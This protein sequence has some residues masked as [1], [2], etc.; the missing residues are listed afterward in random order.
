[1]ESNPKST[2]SSRLMVPVRM[3]SCSI[4][5]G[6]KGFG[7]FGSTLKVLV[8]GELRLE[9][10][11]IDFRAIWRWVL[12]LRGEGDG[13]DNGREATGTNEV[14]GVGLGGI[15]TPAFCGIDPFVTGDPRLAATVASAGGDKGEAAGAAWDLGFGGVGKG[16]LCV[17]AL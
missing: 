5:K 12:L 13:A 11:T 3:G 17:L 14:A 16:T 15:I 1:M 7:G 10:P 6:S 9:W 2:S 8:D 4:W